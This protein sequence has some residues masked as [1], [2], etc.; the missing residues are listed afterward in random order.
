MKLT[1]SA[2]PHSLLAAESEDTVDVH[3]LFAEV[4][5]VQTDAHGPVAE[6]AQS[7]GHGTEVQQAA[8]EIRHKTS[9]KPSDIVSVSSSNS[10]CSSDTYWS[11]LSSTTKFSTCVFTT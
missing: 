3:G 4:S 7:Q 10:V 2:A 1:C 9:L 11:D 8:A 6:L 5:A